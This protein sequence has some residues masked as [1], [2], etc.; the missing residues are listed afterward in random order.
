MSIKCWRGRS[1]T[2][3][4]W[5]LY[6]SDSFAALQTM[7]TESVD[8]VITSPPYYNLRDYKTEGQ[9]G[10]ENTIEEYITALCATMNELRRVLSKSGLL[11]LNLG[12]TYYSGKGRSH[13]IDRKSRKRRFGVRPGKNKL[14]SRIDDSRGDAQ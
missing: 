14:K 5:T 4:D 8:C 2:G 6:N 1:R 3:A 11:F 7:E 9:I 12:D 13:G 10:L